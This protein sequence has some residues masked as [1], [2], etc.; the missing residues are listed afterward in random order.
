DT[1]DV[2]AKG[3]EVEINFNPDRFWTV[4]LN[5]THSQSIDSN[6]APAIPAWIGQRLPVWETII[7][8]R[9]GNK[10]LD[11]PYNGDQIGT[12]QQTPRGFLTGN[13]TS[14][15]ALAQAAQGKSRNSI[16]EWR[17]NASG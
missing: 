6:I 7:D 16:R 15:I 14:P 1:Q 10:W 2:S 3:E 4:K 8:P 11:Q 17:Y 5:V 9:T 13:V 12:T